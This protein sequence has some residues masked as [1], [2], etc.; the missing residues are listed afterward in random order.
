MSMIY[1]WD[2]NKRISNIKKHG[3]DFKNAEYIFT[4]INRIIYP[5]FNKNENRFVAIGFCQ[6]GSFIGLVV[7]TV[8]QDKTRII[9]FR[10]AS[11]KERSFYYENNT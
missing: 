4:D 11:K 8:R 10:R 3:L 1:E 9:S 7:Y 5:A 6:K 2:E